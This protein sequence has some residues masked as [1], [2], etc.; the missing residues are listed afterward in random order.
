MFVVVVYTLTQGCIHQNIFE[1][2]KMFKTAI[3]INLSATFIFSF[4]NSV[5]IYI[6]IYL[7]MDNKDTISS[8]VHDFLG[9]GTQGS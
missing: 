5:Q 7:Y 9:E 8:W 3:E 2:L 6:F 1:T 4:Y